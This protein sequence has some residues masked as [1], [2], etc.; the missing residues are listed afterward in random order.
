M[1]IVKQCKICGR[2]FES[3]T[4]KEK[5]GRGVYC[6][7]ECY[8][9]GFAQHQKLHN[10]NPQNRILKHCET[11]GAELSVVPSLKDRTRFCSKE[12]LYTWQRS[13]TG[14]EHP[15]YTRATKHCEWCGKEYTCKNVHQ[16]RSRFC[17][18]QCQGASTAYNFPVQHTSIE[19]AIAAILDDLDLPYVEQKKLGVF[20]CDFALK[21]YRLVI[22]CD[23]DYW[24]GTKRQKDKDKRKD[25]WLH[26]NGYAVLRLSERDIKRRI[27]WCRAQ[28]VSHLTIP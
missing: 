8:K 13:I 20:V 18:R 24:H 27:H 7:R 14:P 6:S 23:G 28:I 15:L 16:E 2:P 22:E 1:K 17:S 25:G 9:V 4:W 10:R 19:I 5:H 26:A 21:R 12:C 3:D 11:C